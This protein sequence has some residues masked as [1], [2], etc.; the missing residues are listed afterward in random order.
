MIDHICIHMWFDHI[1]FEICPHMIWTYTILVF[2]GVQ[3]YDDH[4]WL[5]TCDLTTYD[6]RTCPHM[7]WTYKVLAFFSV[8]ICDD[9][10]WL[11]IYDLTTYDLKYV[12]IWFEHIW[13]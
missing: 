6:L 11:I 3:I 8:Q 10:M 4:I 2:F 13:F 7:I 9:H 5:I 1:W 12:H